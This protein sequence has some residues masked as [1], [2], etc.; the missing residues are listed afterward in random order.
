MHRYDDGQFGIKP[1]QSVRFCFQVHPLPNV[2]MKGGAAQSST[3]PFAAAS[4]AVDGR[5]DS[6]Y[7]A[8]FCSHTAENEAGPW[9]RVDLRRTHIVRFVKVTNR[10]D[11]CAERLDGAE[12]RIG[13]SLENNGN[14]NPRCASISHIRAG[15]TNTYHCAGGSMDG[16]F[17]NVVIPGERKTLTLCE[18]E[19]YATPTVEPLLNV[20]LHK[21]T[22]QSWGLSIFGGSHHAVGGCRS[23]QYWGICCSETFLQVK[24]WWHLDL[25]AVHKFSAVRILNRR[26]CCA[27]WLND[28]EIRIGNSDSRYRTTNPRCGSISSTGDTSTFTLDC[29][30]MEGRYVA[31]V[32]PKFGMLT[33]CEFEAFASLAD[34]L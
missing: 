13:N 15:K 33:M 27:T 17:V 4:R 11:C 7:S 18:V 34:I 20:A 10:G 2:A 30:G 26:D 3:L 28:A 31:V 6:F 22:G 25:L 21:P 29:A 16:R 9:W 8:G 32:I 19:V 23:G 12:I 24:P 14:N 5:R 1:N